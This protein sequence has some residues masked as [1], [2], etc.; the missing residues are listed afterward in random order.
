MIEVHPRMSTLHITN[1]DGA[2]SVIT[3]SAVQGDVL[4]WRD[5]M[6]FGPFPPG[7]SFDELGALRAAFLSGPGIDHD[8][9]LRQF[10]QRDDQIRRCDRYDEIILWF[11]HDLL[12]PVS[13]TH[14]RA[15]ET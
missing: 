4:P 13:Y 9:T 2:A 5:P 3:A 15:H 10:R 14:L 8:A 11:E 6:H 1:G 12:D 7:L